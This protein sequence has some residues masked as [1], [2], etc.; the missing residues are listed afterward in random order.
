MIWQ[1][2]AEQLWQLDKQP[3][4]LWPLLSA[5][6]LMALVSWCGHS[7]WAFQALA[8]VTQPELPVSLCGCTCCPFSKLSG[9][10]PGSSFLYFRP[11]QWGICSE[12]VLQQR[13]SESGVLPHHHPICLETPS[14]SGAEHPLKCLSPLW[15]QGEQDMACSKK[16]TFQGM[17]YFPAFCSFSYSNGT[18]GKGI[19]SGKGANPSCSVCT[20]M[21]SSPSTAA[22]AA[23]ERRSKTLIVNTQHMENTKRAIDLLYCLV[24]STGME[25]TAAQSHF[26]RKSCPEY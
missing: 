17:K 11:W 4:I 18:D 2:R 21:A 25:Q 8:V 19:N 6:W 14:W 10:C 15:L 23:E 1:E 20:S 16:A 9:S 13:I 24:L 5:K 7:L 12:L 26:V 22:T 3:L